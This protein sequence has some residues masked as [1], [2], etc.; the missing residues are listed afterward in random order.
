MLDDEE[1]RQKRADELKRRRS[2]EAKQ[3]IGQRSTEARAVFERH[4]SQG[5]FR[6]KQQTSSSNITND[7]IEESKAPISGSGAPISG[8]DAPISPP[9]PSA[10]AAPTPK[11][12]AINANE[13]ST[14]DIVVPP[15]MDFGNDDNRISEIQ[16]QQQQQPQQHPQRP[17]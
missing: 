10:F 16:Q 15:P 4:S 1:S 12:D 17:Q 7:V 13:V 8:S 6:S 14:E 5:Q 2:Q 9:V 3:L 11:E